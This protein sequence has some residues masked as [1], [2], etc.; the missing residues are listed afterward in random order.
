[1]LGVCVVW[2]IT[3]GNVRDLNYDWGEKKTK[4]EVCVRVCV[5]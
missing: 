5:K 2:V 1:M 3:L 4:E